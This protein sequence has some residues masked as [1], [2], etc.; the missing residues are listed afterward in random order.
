MD[1]V[2]IV[3][4]DVDAV[5]AFVAKLGMELEAETTVEAPWIESFI[6]EI[7][8]HEDSHRLCFIRGPEGIILGLEEELSQDR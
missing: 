5:K 2:L 4:E 3:V 6:G 7:A 1:N 8:Q